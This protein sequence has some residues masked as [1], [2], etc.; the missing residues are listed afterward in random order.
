[1]GFVSLDIAETPE[2]EACVCIATKDSVNYAT[3]TLHS[4]SFA[5]STDTTGNPL[6]RPSNLVWQKTA[7]L[8]ID[9]AGSSIIDVSCGVTSDG[10]QI[11]AGTKSENTAATYVFYTKGTSPT[12]KYVPRAEA[13]VEVVDNLPAALNPNWSGI[14]TLYKAVD[15]R[16]TCSATVLSQETGARLF[17]YRLLTNSIGD[18]TYMFSMLTP[19]K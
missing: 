16:A 2:G 1:M 6:F 8:Q 12:W 15:G 7:P 9:E 13:A 17:N 5:L 11:L 19:W 4:S 3:F 14:F 10:F 18:A